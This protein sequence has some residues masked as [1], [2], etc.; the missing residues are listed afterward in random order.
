MKI[1]PLF[2]CLVPKTIEIES[3]SAE[4]RQF[5]NHRLRDHVDVT[6]DCLNLLLHA[7]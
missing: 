2:L 6:I 3:L 7:L 4:E 5:S 1:I